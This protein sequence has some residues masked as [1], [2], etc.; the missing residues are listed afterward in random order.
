MFMEL[1]RLGGKENTAELSSDDNKD[2]TNGACGMYGGKE[3]CR[4]ILHS[5]TDYLENCIT[6]HVMQIIIDQTATYKTVE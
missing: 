6:P 1:K 3:R 2:E 4:C 5:T